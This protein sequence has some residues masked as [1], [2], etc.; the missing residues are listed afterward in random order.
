MQRYAQ[1][2]TGA[3]RAVAGA[4]GSSG[5]EVELAREQVDEVERAKRH[6]RLEGETAASGRRRR[7]I[8]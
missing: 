7:R 5:A 2:Q 3:V 8:G 6:H 1:L 4:A